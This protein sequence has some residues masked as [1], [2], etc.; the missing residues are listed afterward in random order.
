MYVQMRY[1]KIMTSKE[2]AIKSIEFRNVY[3]QKLGC[4]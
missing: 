4:I 2:I 3:K 1:T